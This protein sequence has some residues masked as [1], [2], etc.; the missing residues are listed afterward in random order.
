MSEV[1]EESSYGREVLNKATVEIN[2]A[3]EG[4]YISLVLRGRPIADSGDFYKVHR[5]FVLQNDQ[6]KVL[7]LPLVELT[8][9]WAKE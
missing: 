8:F 3:Y 9:L 6:S 1:E 2:K 4:L 7:D 5:N